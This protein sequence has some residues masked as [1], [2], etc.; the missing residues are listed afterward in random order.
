MECNP[1]QLD[2]RTFKSQIQF[3]LSVGKI[4]RRCQGYSIGRNFASK[5]VF[6]RCLYCLCLL[7]LRESLFLFILIHRP[8]MLSALL[9]YAAAA[10]PPAN[11]RVD[12]ETN[13]G[14]RTRETLVPGKAE[15]ER[16]IGSG[17]R[18]DARADRRGWIV[19]EG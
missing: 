1:A 13:G 6:L 15:H 17:G 3:S 16:R 7:C 11:T 19:G 4:P 8:L 12:L 9:F 14:W 2:H 5:G 18:L 10:A